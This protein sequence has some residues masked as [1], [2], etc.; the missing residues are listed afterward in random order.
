M[1]LSDLGTA[2]QAAARVAMSREGLEVAVNHFVL[3]RS[4]S[5]VDMDLRTALQRGSHM[6]ERG[7]HRTPDA[8][9]RMVLDI[10]MWGSTI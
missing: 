1:N 5:H 2:E 8:N 10:Q 9:F 3:S 4:V 6:R 7:R